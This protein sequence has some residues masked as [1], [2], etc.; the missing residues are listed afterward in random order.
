MKERTVEPKTREGI[1]VDPE[2]QPPPLQDSR[3]RQ[4]SMFQTLRHRK[5]MLDEIPEAQRVLE[6]FGLRVLVGQ[7]PVFRAVVQQISTFARCPASILL[8]GETGTGKELCARAL[9]YLSA[10]A[11]GPFVPVN[12]GAIPQDLMENELFGHVAG[13]FTGATTSH[14]GVLGEAE[15]G[16]LFLDEIEGLSLLAQ[17]KLLRFVQ[18]HEYRPLG[19]T[20]R[21]A[22]NVRLIAATNGNLED[23]VRQGA[24]RQDLYYRLKV[25]VLELPP[26]RQRRE[27]IPLLAQYFLDKYAAEFNR[28]AKHLSADALQVLLRY[29]WPGNVRELEHLI[30]RAVALSD[31]AMLDASMLAVPGSEKVLPQESFHAAKAKAVA[32]FEK[33]YLQQILT[34]HH[35]N[36]TK[37]AQIAQKNRRAFWQL[38]RKHGL[39][40]Q[41]PKGAD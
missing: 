8:L 2:V 41:N 40:V 33:M 25:L 22:A 5:P 36:I 24:F 35:G 23:A 12:C 30:E 3:D 31:Q 14:P 20:K 16:T 11:S 15:G 4:S 39:H 34:A 26:L 17:V 37:A 9:H 19:A 27:D 38:L 13:A 29:E 28:P 1:E 18:E 10:R 7:S 21:R 6:S 32:R